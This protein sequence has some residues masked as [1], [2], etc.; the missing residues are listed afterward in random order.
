[1]SNT[2]SV[3]R[4]DNVSFAVARMYINRRRILLKSVLE[5]LAEESDEERRLRT[6]SR[7]NNRQQGVRVEQVIH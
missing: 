2:Y 4:S 1:M 3:D 7:Q 5:E 6:H